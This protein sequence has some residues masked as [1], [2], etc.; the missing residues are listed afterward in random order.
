MN[1]GK[2]FTTK[3]TK[4]TKIFCGTTQHYAITMQDEFNFGVTMI[5][6]RGLRVLRG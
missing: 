4:S 5:L 3:L 2:L 6:L 1:P